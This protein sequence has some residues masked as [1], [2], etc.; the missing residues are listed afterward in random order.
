MKVTTLSEKAMLVKL[1]TR[2]ANLT[3]RDT[4]VEQI[5]QQQFDD[6]SLIVNTKLFRDKDN[7]INQIVSAMSEGYTYHKNNT[8]PYID[9]GPRILPN[10]VYM[11]YTSEM[12]SKISNVDALLNKHMPNYDQ[13]VQMDIQYR[14]KGNPAS[15]A[16]IED[17]PTADEFA[18]R[19]GFALRFMPLPDQKHFL[20]DL[21][22]EDVANFSQAMI[23]AETTARNDALGRMLEPLKHLVE[24]LNKPIK[25]EGSVFRD[26]AIENIIEGVEVARKLMIDPTPEMQQVMNTLDQAVS[27]YANNKDWL[28]ESP[29]V[30]EQAA[31]QLDDIAKQMG[32]FMGA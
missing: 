3:R 21:S 16:K 4:A 5:V 13:Y 7:P 26:S 23:D 11:E 31:K 2:R 22:D 20:F 6:A 10:N 17:Y 8:L 28:R 18:S 9:K 24:K 14:S 25:A 12:R 15:R 19:M 27:K 29:I 32:A 1:T 30:R